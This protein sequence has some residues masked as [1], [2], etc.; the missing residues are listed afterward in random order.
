VAEEQLAQG[1]VLAA[2]Q[3]EEQRVQLRRWQLHTCML[4][5]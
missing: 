3:A 1:L 2:E 4:H 5:P